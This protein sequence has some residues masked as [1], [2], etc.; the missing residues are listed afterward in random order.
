MKFAICQEIFE[1]WDWERQCRFIA[2]VGYQGIEV[3]PF[4]LAERITDLSHDRRRVLRQQAADNGLQIIGLHWLLAKT[5]GLH[6]TSGDSAVRKATAEYLVAL[7]S[8]CADLGGEILVFGSPAQ[9]SLKPGTSR[10][11]GFVRAADVLRQCLPALADRGVKFCLEPLTPQETNF[12]NTCADAV[13]LIDQVGEPNLRL[14]Q[15][16]KAMLS[17]PE[18]IPSLIA[19]YRTRVGHF[20]ANDSNLQG[21][22]MGPTDL[23]PIF[24]ALVDTKYAGW[25]SVEPFDYSPGCERLARESLANMR[26]ALARVG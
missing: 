8:A 21:P 15:D 14:H 16:V 26:E 11:E 9:R 20:H 19:R 17:E 3:A 22:G 25:V 4:A 12:L 2:Q 13:E 7:G 5:T 24:R 10:E 18:T 6:F 1:D 23:V